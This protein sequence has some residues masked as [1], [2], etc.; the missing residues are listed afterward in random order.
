MMNIMITSVSNYIADETKRY[1]EILNE[2]FWCLNTKVIDRYDE[3]QIKFNSYKFNADLAL[4]IDK[5]G[6]A[7]F[8]K[9]EKRSFF[10]KSQQVK[11]VIAEWNDFA[12]PFEA[13]LAIQLK[14]YKVIKSLIMK[15]NSYS[16]RTEEFTSDDEII[17][18]KFLDEEL[19]IEED[20]ELDDELENKMSL[21]NL[22]ST[23]SPKLSSCSTSSENGFSI[24][25]PFMEV[26][27]E[28][29]LDFFEEV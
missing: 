26:N 2:N 21:E 17:F 29:Y 5:D 15:E 27:E 6:Q 9:K 19:E 7:Y 12:D 8:L 13:A 4:I 3:V 10:K 24:S 22:I 25:P 1:A 20:T 11:M 14:M 16:C 18:E 28:S 23:Q